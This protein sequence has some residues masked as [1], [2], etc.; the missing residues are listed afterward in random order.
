MNAAHLHLIINHAPLFSALFGTLILIMAMIRNSKELRAVAVALFVFGALTTVASHLTGDEA[1]DVVKQ[2]SGINLE[3]V[4]PAIHEHDKASDFA[5]W[6]SIIVAVAS[7]GMFWA[8]HKNSK[9]LKK[10]QIVVLIL[11]IHSC[12]VMMRVAYLGG[13][14]RH[15][16]I[17]SS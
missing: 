5:L 10:L 7:T 13:L 6:S 1:E 15:T 16:E 11:A 9:H 14:I 12:T 8:S 17:Q 4:K 2:I 3:T